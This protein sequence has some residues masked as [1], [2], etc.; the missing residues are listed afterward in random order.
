MSNRSSQRKATPCGK[1]GFE[2][3]NPVSVLHVSN[4]GLYNDARHPGRLI[5]TLR[6]HCEHFDQLRP[7]TMG[8]F[9]YDVQKCAGIL[10]RVEGVERVNIAIMGNKIPHVHAHV[11]PRYTGEPNIKR[12]PWEDAA[13]LTEMSEERLDA[14]VALIKSM[15]WADTPLIATAVTE[16]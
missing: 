14:M 16:S 4:V 1:C 13:P 2:L 9:M 12:S 6:R 11:I 10:R 3:Y 15:F 7:D 8:M 5:V